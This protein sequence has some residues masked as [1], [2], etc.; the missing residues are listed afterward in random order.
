MTDAVRCLYRPDHNIFPLAD[1][2]P[3]ATNTETTKARNDICEYLDAH[4]MQPLFFNSQ[5]QQARVEESVNTMTRAERVYLEIEMH[6]R[7]RVL[8]SFDYD[9]IR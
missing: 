6:D 8:H 5:Q 2:A 1:G 3:R 9:P 4:L 7:A